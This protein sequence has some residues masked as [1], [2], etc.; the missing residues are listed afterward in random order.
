MLTLYVDTEAWRA[1]LAAVVQ[2][3]PGLVPVAKGNGYGFHNARLAHEAAK[4]GADMLAV[5]TVR[6]IEQVAPEYFG[7]LLVLTPYRTTQGPV[8]RS[9][10]VVYTV[11]D[12]E[13][14]LTLRGRRVVIEC[15]TSLRRHGITE[16][17]LFRVIPAL[18]D[19]KLEGFALHLPLDRPAGVDP[20]AEVINWVARLRSVGAPLQTLFVS[21][22]TPEEMATLAQKFPDISFRPRIGTK[23]WLGDRS[24]FQVKA[25]VL[26]V[27]KIERGDR[28][29]YRQHKALSDGHLVV[30]TG[31][32]AHGIGL[33]APKAFR[34]IMPRAK[35]M[36]TA[37]LAQ[38]NAAL[39]PF[40]WEG[41]QR[42][43]AE[44]PHM[45]VSI[46]MLPSDVRPP[47][48]GEELRADVR[49]TITNFDRIVER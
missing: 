17:E 35:G 10:R 24:V 30:V 36:A 39:S 34:G 44:P 49:M 38:I 27:I 31:G 32:T 37:G 21:H 12:L 11:S 13:G 5:G 9:N 45:Q 1:R 4:F 33:S 19:V 8:D 14:L 16:Q 48:V 28:Y 43:F 23:L 2:D 18:S 22:L 40:S 42:W 41:K 20:I 25:P 7:D 6:E 3:N 47:V 26:D 29:G 15:L 46:L